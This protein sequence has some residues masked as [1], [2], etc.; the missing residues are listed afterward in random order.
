[1]QVTAARQSLEMQQL[2]AYS[3]PVG[4]D[5]QPMHFDELSV[6]HDEMLLTR[7]RI[8]QR[9]K[10]GGTTASGCSCWHTESRLFRSHAPAYLLLAGPKK[11]K[12]MY[13]VV[14]RW[15]HN[16]RVVER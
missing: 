1:M 14:R 6:R 5:G 2:G 10:R 16:Q 12:A 8:E 13:V 7:S 15:E 4:W 3:G 11:A 9:L